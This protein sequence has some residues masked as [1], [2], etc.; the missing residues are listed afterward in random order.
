MQATFQTE[1]TLKLFAKLD[2]VLLQKKMDMWKILNSISLET[3][4]QPYMYFH[5][6][7]LELTRE[8]NFKSQTIRNN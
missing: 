4:V 8:N 2:T 7:K 5:S 1:S 3:D 6:I